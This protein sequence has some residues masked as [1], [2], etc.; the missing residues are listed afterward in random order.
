[1]SI[2]TVSEVGGGLFKGQSNERDEVKCIRGSIP[3][4]IT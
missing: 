2:P 4:V 1:M 3:T